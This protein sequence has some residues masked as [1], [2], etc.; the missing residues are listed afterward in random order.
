MLLL[1]RCLKFLASKTSGLIENLAIV[2]NWKNF[3]TFSFWIQ[4]IWLKHTYFCH[5]NYFQWVFQKSLHYLYWKIGKKLVK[6]LIWD[7]TMS[8]AACTYLSSD[9]HLANLTILLNLH[10]PLACCNEA[11]LKTHWKQQKK[12]SVFHCHL[13]QVIF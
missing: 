1:C 8:A 11:I 2:K 5:M 4:I 7:V 12:I 6:N 13:Q 3:W 10:Y 9:W